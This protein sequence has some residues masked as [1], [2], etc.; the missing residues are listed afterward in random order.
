MGLSEALRPVSV[1]NCHLAVFL[2]GFEAAVGFS[3]APQPVSI[4]FE[5]A[6]RHVSSSS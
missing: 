6:I 4:G 2:L 1:G 3:E 5:T